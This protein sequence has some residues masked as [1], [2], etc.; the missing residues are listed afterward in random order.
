MIDINITLF[1]Q[2]VNIHRM[3]YGFCNFA[4]E[5]FFFRLFSFGNIPHNGQHLMGI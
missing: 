1:I 4:D 3:G 2:I 5:A